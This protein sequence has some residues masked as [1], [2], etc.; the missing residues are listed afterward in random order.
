MKGGFSGGTVDSARTQVDTLKRD[1]S[2]R[3]DRQ[4]PVGPG[5]GRPT[6]PCAEG[7]P[8]AKAGASSSG[9]WRR[10]C[11]GPVAGLVAKVE[12]AS[13]VRREE[14]S[15][16]FTGPFVMAA[17]NTRVVARSASLL[18]YGEGFR[19]RE[20]ADFG[21]G[22]KGAVT[23]GV[24]SAA[25]L[26]V[27][28]GLSFPPVRPVVDRLLPKPGEGPSAEAMTSGRFR[29]EVTAEA[30]NGARYRS[31]V[32]APYDPGYSGTAVMFGEAALALCDDEAAAGRRVRRPHARDRPSGC[33]WPTGCGPT[34]SPSTSHRLTD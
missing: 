13:P 26:G 20:Y 8:S 24:T 34:A 1:P 16:H 19:Y 17:F 22:V 28:G 10:G 25:L 5:R 6:A 21:S 32:F 18:G 29:M 3:A 15:D 33:R 12:K 27:L 2:A 31:T 11:P 4:R 30:T 23:A 9:V 7:A 14:G